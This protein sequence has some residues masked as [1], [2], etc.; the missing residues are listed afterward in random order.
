MS[1]YIENYYPKNTS[2]CAPKINRRVVK[3]IEKRAYIC[4]FCLESFNKLINLKKHFIEDKICNLWLKNHI[5]I[6]DRKWYRK[7]KTIFNKKENI[8]NYF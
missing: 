7:Y 3:N 2:I 5:E 4:F 8:Y 6:K 1:I